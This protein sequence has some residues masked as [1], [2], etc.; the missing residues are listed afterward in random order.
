MTKIKIGRESNMLDF[1]NS[2]E[3]DMLS[4]TL[5]DDLS[6]NIR[7]RG[8]AM[9]DIHNLWHRYNDKTGEITIIH[10]GEWDIEMR[11]LLKNKYGMDDETINRFR[12]QYFEHIR[13]S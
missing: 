2:F 8:S 5:N 6:N 4:N 1:L 12:G 13:R 11:E 3:I 9:S 7:T 10:E